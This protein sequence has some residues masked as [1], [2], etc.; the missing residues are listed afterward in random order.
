MILEKM[1]AGIPQI[2]TVLNLRM[3][4]TLIY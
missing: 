2:K 1:V 3:H 4:A